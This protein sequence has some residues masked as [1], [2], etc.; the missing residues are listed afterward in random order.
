MTRSSILLLA[1][2]PLLACSEPQKSP[3][4]DPNDN[5]ADNNATDTLETQ[6]TFVG[7]IKPLIDRKCNVCHA[8]GGLGPFPLETYAQVTTMSAAIRASVEAGTMPPW[9]PDA[10]C[11][12]YQGDLSL[13]EP[14]KQ[15]LLEWIDAKTPQGSPDQAVPSEPPATGNLSRVDLTLSLPQPYAPQILPDDYR[16]FIVDWPETSPKFITGF[17]V[18]P[19]NKAIVHHAIAFNI[20]PDSVPQFQALDDAEEGPGYTCY[21]GPGGD[22]GA[23]GNGGARWVGAWVPGSVTGDFPQGTGIKIEPGSKLV[24]QMHLNSLTANPAPDQSTFDIQIADTVEREAVV[25]PFAN[26]LWLRDNTM[27][28]PAGDPAASHSFSFDP[29]A[30]LD[31]LS[32]GAIPNGDFVIH[33]AALHMHTLG[34]QAS[35]AIERADDQGDTCLLHIPKW[36]FHW[37]GTYRTTQPITF[38]RGDKLSLSCT[39]DNS[40][41]NQPFVPT[42][43]D[44]DGQMDELAQAPP[45]D[46]NWG[47]GTFDEMCLGILYITAP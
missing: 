9:M 40:P 31:R 11:N 44:Q 25:M 6:L 23:G 4:P 39:W 41:Q 1:L 22:F 5:N 43:T 27:T 28:I 47:E 45:R 12:T 24:I 42:D 34:A 10:A 18:N 46:V 3:A 21:G 16:C 37:Q 15:K 13:S 26:P 32:R 30:F 33:A 20:P 35:I 38:K 2:L 7:D 8:E 14:E 17:R 19:D 36:D 29:T